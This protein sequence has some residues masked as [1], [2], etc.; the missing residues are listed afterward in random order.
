MKEVKI[1]K[2]KPTSHPFEIEN[3]MR[4]DIPQGKKTVKGL[5]EAAPGQKDNYIKVK[6]ILK[7]TK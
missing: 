6:T 3:V 4:K 7:Q 2:V 5:V 1:G